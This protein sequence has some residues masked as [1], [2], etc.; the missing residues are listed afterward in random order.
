MLPATAAS[1]L[2]SVWAALGGRSEA[3][4]WWVTGE[5]LSGPA[6]GRD[7]GRCGTTAAL[8][9]REQLVTARDE[10][11]RRA[12][13]ELHDGLGPSLAALAL[14]VETARDLTPGTR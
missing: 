9:H 6:R 14:Q 3:P 13:R 10:E 4:N 8:R 7:V 5:A 12:Y 1:L 2:G 11:R